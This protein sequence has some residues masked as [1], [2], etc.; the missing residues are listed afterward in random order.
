LSR[1]NTYDELQ[2]LNRHRV[3]LITQGLILVAAAALSVLTFP[4][5][6]YA[7]LLLGFTFVLGLGS[8]HGNPARQA[9]NAEIV[10][11][12]ELPAEVTLSSISY[13]LALA[14]I[15]EVFSLSSC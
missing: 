8:I 15:R 14:M 3:L 10:P 13:N 1:G 12:D 7:P 9:L 2:S 11:A 6:M 4:G 5:R